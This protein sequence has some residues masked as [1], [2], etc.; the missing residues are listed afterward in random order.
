MT[1]RNDLPKIRVLSRSDGFALLDRHARAELR[2]SG[3]TFLRRWKAG[4][5]AKR[6][7]RPEVVRVA[8]LLPL[9]R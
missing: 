5:Y 4:K 9:A 8:M 7:D 6:A 3:K 2:V 1:S